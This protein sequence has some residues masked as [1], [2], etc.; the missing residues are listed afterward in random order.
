MWSW[1]FVFCI[2][3]SQFMYY[4]GNTVSNPLFNETVIEVRYFN[5]LW[6]YVQKSCKN[7]QIV[8][9]ID[10]MLQIQYLSV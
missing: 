9:V 2:D 6:S 8:F 4:A 1:K 3:D 7:F 10:F 5:D